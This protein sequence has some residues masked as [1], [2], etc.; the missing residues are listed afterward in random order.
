MS[1]SSSLGR[2]SSPGHGRAGETHSLNLPDT[3]QVLCTPYAT[4]RETEVTPPDHDKTRGTPSQAKTKTRPQS[5]SPNIPST[6]Q[7]LSTF[8]VTKE[9]MEVISALK[10][11][12]ASM[13]A[14]IERQRESIQKGRMSVTTTEMMI[15]AKRGIL[16]RSEAKSKHSLAMQRQKK[17]IAELERGMSSAQ[18]QVDAWEAGGEKKWEIIEESLKG[19]TKE[20]LN[21]E[22]NQQPDWLKDYCEK[23]RRRLGME[24]CGV[25][26]SWRSIHDHPHQI[27]RLKKEMISLLGKDEESEWASLKPQ[28]SRL[29]EKFDS[30]DR[31]GGER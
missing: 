22:S 16:E 11:H 7:V 10:G 26:Q 1:A 15:E 28:R 24:R 20:L 2:A 4:R 9:E 18:L 25:E 17:Q 5:D 12:T 21:L 31:K 13:R 14:I 6:P 8:Y 3:S 30:Q 23:E 19:L 29:A 27:E